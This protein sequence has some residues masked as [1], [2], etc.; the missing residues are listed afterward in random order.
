MTDNN[1]TKTER[2]L[3]WLR[4]N[5]QNK[6]WG[7]L[8]IDEK[9][10]ARVETFGSLVK[11]YEMRPQTIVGQI[12]S[13]QRAVTLIDCFPVNTEDGLWRGDGQPDWS[14]QTC[15]VNGVVDGLWFGVGEEI[16]FEQVF[17][18][19]STLTK[20]ANPNQVKLD[21][22]K[23]ATGPAWLSI[24]IEDRASE[25]ATVTYGGQELRI[26]LRFQ[27]K[28]ET[29]SR[30]SGS[31]VLVEDHCY[32]TIERSDGSRMA[33]ESIISVLG[34]ALDLLSICCNETS[35]VTSFHA[36]HSKGD[37]DP[38][39]LHIPLKGYDSKIE[40]SQPLPAL[41][42]TDIG[43]IEGLAR[44]FEVREK[45]GE[46]ATRLTSNWYVKGGYSEDSFSRVYA[47]VEGLL[48]R[49]RNRSRAKMKDSE[50][51][52]FV[53][54]AIPD[55]P[56]T[57]G[58]VA[59]EWANKVKTVRDQKVD[60]SD[61][62]STIKADGRSMHVMTNVMYVAGASFL[63]KEMGLGDEQI[64]QYIEGCSGSFLLKEQY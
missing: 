57:I 38:V 6:L 41:S 64:A 56:T 60:H 48:A 46:A 49:K 11:P 52:E 39:K 45:Y 2:G 20:W 9:N 44:W 62:S 19:I 21:F 8:F 35:K 27:P 53:D 15:V 5:D 32:L 36:Y 59:E 50:L 51:A 13:G 30:I 25:T 47:A 18:N 16:T 1:G 14:Y 4:E 7:T 43:G 22:P 42:F 40:R 34:V 17:I 55:C 23:G 33:L 29:S 61:P 31:R 28:Q 54:T 26:S 24:S 12:R 58:G 37:G 10:E 3:F 63:L